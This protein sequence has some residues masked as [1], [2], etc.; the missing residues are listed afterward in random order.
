M[1]R[2][3]GG[4][5]LHKNTNTTVVEGEK[6]GTVVAVE[7][8]HQR[9]AAQGRKEAVGIGVEAVGALMKLEE[10]SPVA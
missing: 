7:V 10:S 1:R 3:T 5:I 2:T 4:A 8:G 6:V 9:E